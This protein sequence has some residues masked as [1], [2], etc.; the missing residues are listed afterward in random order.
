VIGS[1]I[2]TGCDVL[3]AVFLVAGAV[4]TLA[5]AAGLLRFADVIARLHAGTKPQVLGVLLVLTGVALRFREPRVLGLVAIAALF[6]LMTVPVSSHLIARAA[7]RS[8]A[9]REDLLVVDELAT[10]RP[11]A[12]ATDEDT[13]TP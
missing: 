8:G 7:Y 6:Q 10:E 2:A 11:A 5:A 12:E 13:P 3:A 1:A 4:L 9:F